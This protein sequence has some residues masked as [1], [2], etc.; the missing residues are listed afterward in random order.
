[1]C[2]VIPVSGVKR[3]GLSFLST[4]HF[5][6]NGGVSPIF[7]SRLFLYGYHRVCW[8]IVG[9]FLDGDTMG[10]IGVFG[11]VKVFLLYVAT[12][13]FSGRYS[14]NTR[15]NVNLYLSALM[16]SL[17]P[18]VILTSCVASDNLTRGVNERL[19]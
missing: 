3:N 16:P 5:F 1:M 8:L 2:N 17:F 7:I 4:V 9:V 13:L 10:T 19:S 12:L 18:F 11:T 15:G 6:F 14:G